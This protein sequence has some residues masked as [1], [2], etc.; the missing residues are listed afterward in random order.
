MGN[1][2]LLVRAGRQSCSKHVDSFTVFVPGVERT[3][4][5]RLGPTHAHLLGEELRHHGHKAHA[6]EQGRQGGQQIAQ[7]GTAAQ[8]G[9]AGVATRACSAHDEEA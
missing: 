8:G 7:Q 4:R 1:P 3:E 5:R 2:A 6:V 9:E